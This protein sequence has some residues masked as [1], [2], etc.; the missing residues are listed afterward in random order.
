M[1]PFL[2]GKSR[3]KMI[4]GNQV[5]ADAK[6]DKRVSGSSWINFNGNSIIGAS[7]QEDEEPVS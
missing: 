6:E 7:L 1:S 5:R 2:N 4:F 3:G